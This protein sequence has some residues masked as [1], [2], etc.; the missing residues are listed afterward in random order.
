MMMIWSS[1]IDL[2]MRLWLRCEWFGWLRCE[3]CDWDVSWDV[4]DLNDLNDEMWFGCDWFEWSHKHHTNSIFW[5]FF[6]GIWSEMKNHLWQINLWF[7]FWQISFFC[8]FF[9]FWISISSLNLNLN[10]PTPIN[11]QKKHLK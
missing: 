4:N 5:A 3:W 8:D 1:K 7:L 9:F 2:Q 10:T 11:K 6:F